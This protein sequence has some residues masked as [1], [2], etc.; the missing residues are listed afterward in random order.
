M[1]KSLT[2]VLATVFVMT[3]LFPAFGEVK[4]AGIFS[5]HMIL[6]R[7][8]PVNIWGT[9]SPNEIVT[10]SFAGQSVE[11]K[12]DSNGDWLLKLAPLKMSKKPQSM[13]IKGENTIELSDVL[14]GEVWLCSGQSNMADSFCSKEGHALDPN[15]YKRDH[16]LLRV[17]PSRGQWTLFG[18]DSLRRFPRVGYYFGMKLIENIDMPVGLIH[19]A[20]SATPIQ[21]WMSPDAA[22]KVRVKLNI[23]KHWNDPKN[24]HTG[25]LQFN[26]CIKP[27]IPATFRGVIWYQGERNAKTQ[28]GVEYKELLVTLIE[29]WRELWAQKS[30]SKLRKFPF[31]YVQVPT[32]GDKGGVAMEWP[33]LRNS[34]RMALDLTENTGMAIFYDW[35]P[36]LHPSNKKVAGERLALWALAKDYGKTNIVPCGPLLDKV[37]IDGNKALLS[38]KYIGGGLK[39]KSGEKNLKFFEIAGEDAKY[40]SAEATIQGDIVVVESDKVSAPIYVRYLFRKVKP[41]AEVSLINAEGLP[42]SS[43]LTDSVMP[44]RPEIEPYNEQM[45]ID[46]AAMVKEKAKI[47]AEINKLRSTMTPQEFRKLKMKMERDAKKRIKEQSNKKD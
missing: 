30:G 2:R 5:D 47:M 38:F 7:E 29:S 21:G 12:A 23:A 35:G 31:Y 25:G 24:P 20:R 40:V 32:Q 19:Q 36:S 11:A 13:T 37:T 33:Y 17:S 3:S 18:K 26:E 42:A 1:N 10:V 4:V 28:T 34:M 27:I 45:A 44:F 8:L 22:E 16:S 6:Q 46:R 43:F 39:N 14:I 15:D 9:A 41:D